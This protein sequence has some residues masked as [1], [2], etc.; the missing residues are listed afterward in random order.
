MWACPLYTWTVCPLTTAPWGV[1]YNVHPFNKYQFRSALTLLFYLIL[2]C[3]AVTQS[4][5][6]TF[7]SF[8]LSCISACLSLLLLDFSILWILIPPQCLRSPLAF[9]K[10]LSLFLCVST[11]FVSRWFPLF[12]SLDVSFGFLILLTQPVLISPYLSFCSVSCPL[13]HTLTHIVKLFSC[14]LPADQSWHIS[15]LSCKVTEL[16]DSSQLSGWPISARTHT[17]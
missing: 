6:L 9:S 2:C 13:F 5:L 8:V 16:L 14:G 15:H 3:A 17:F 12:H 7:L 11:L 10:T 1:D 4:L